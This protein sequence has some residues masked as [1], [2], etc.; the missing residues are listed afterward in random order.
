MILS[1]DKRRLLLNDTC[2]YQSHICLLFN[3]TTY[4]ITILQFWHAGI[5]AESKVNQ[6]TDWIA[7][8]RHVHIN[9]TVE[10][11]QNKT[12]QVTDTDS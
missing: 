2:D 7:I 10:K 3:F 9:R 4:F 12:G 1:Y 8:L 6:Y 11:R 5:G